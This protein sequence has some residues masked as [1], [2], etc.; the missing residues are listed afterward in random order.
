MLLSS[1][2]TLERM[3]LDETIDNIFLPN[4]DMS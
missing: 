2:R 1:A 3:Y 4:T